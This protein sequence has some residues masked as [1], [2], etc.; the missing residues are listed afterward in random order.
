MLSVTVMLALVVVLFA[1]SLVCDC[2]LVYMTKDLHQSGRK[3]LGKTL[4]VSWGWNAA[5]SVDEGKNITS[6]FKFD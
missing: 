3:G 2:A 5:V 6:A 1:S 4:E